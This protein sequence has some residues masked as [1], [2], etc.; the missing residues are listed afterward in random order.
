[1]NHPESV[2]VDISGNLYIA[3]YFN[4]VIRKVTT[5]GI[6]STVAGNGTSGH[7]GDGGL[8]TSA[9]LKNPLN[10]TFD[11]LSSGWLILQLDLP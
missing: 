2:T 10:V 3:D 7:S 8:A 1:L 5:A 11:Q 9:Q 6:I 4:A